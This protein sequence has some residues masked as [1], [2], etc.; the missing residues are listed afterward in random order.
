M[1]PSVGDEWEGYA[2]RRAST[3]DMPALAA[4]AEQD[5]VDGGLPRAASARIGRGEPV[6]VLEDLG[7][8]RVISTLVI[9][10]CYLNSVYTA[11]E[12]RKGGLG[13]KAVAVLVAH[14]FSSSNEEALY[15]TQ[16]VSPHGEQM[17]EKLGFARASDGSG[18]YTLTRAQWGMRRNEHAALFGSASSTWASK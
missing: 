5:D 16:P 17:L 1:I 7:T 2:V 11:A 4:W 6:Y 3:D 12:H 10:A 18:S 9:R 8:K 13:T 14:Y 15:V